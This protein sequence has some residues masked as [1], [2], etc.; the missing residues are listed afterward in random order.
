LWTAR[1]EKEERRPDGQLRHLLTDIRPLDPS[2]GASSDV[3]AAGAGSSQWVRLDTGKMTWSDERGQEQ[4]FELCAHDEGAGSAAP[5]SSE[6][7]APAAAATAAAARAV[8][9]P[10]QVLHVEDDAAFKALLASGVPVIVDFSATWCGPCKAIAPLFTE[11][12]AEHPQTV[13]AKVDV[14]ECEETAETH[15]V[16]AMP[17]FQAFSGGQKIDTFSGADKQQLRVFVQRHCAAGTATA[18]ATAA[19]GSG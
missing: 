4:L 13:F 11:L 3:G 9:A 18:T 1:V 2:D 12:A 16:N 6:S 10:G 19:T 14:D 5:D 15:G 17:T 7:D 8:P